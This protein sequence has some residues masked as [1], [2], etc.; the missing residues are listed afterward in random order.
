[1]TEHEL[2]SLLHVHVHKNTDICTL[3]F[4]IARTMLKIC[5]IFKY[6][7]YRNKYTVV[8]LN[9]PDA[10]Y[11]CNQRGRVGGVILSTA[12]NQKQKLIKATVKQIDGCSFCRIELAAHFTLLES[13]IT[14]DYIKGPSW[15]FCM[16]QPNGK[17]AIYFINILL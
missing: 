3:G 14:L 13:D 8:C 2:S 10:P 4:E 11:T 1:M 9:W 12:D 6:C 16:I 5:T 15:C 7:I 17:V